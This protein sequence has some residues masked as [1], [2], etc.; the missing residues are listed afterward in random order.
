MDKKEV[1]V[2]I[3]A[4]MKEKGLTQTKV[5]DMLGIKQSSVSDMISG[6]RDTVRLAL[7][8][9]NYYS[10]SSDIF[11]G[12]NNKYVQNMAERDIINSLNV[13]ERKN[14]INNLHDLYKKHEDLLNEACSVMKQ[15]ATI[16]KILIIGIE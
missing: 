9:A 16:N 6:R 10:L 1:G 5:A 2:R 4:F 13:D 11:L 3:K 8:L 12:S 7:D 14:L 15:I